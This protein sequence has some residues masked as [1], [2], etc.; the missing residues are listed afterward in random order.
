[1]AA[2]RIYTED[3][4]IAS[5]LIKRDGVIT[6]RYLYK[7]CYPLFKSIYDSYYT[8]CSCCKEFIDE[9]YLVV[10]SPSKNT[11]KCQLENYR[12]ESTLTSWLK[13]VCL[14]YCY[15]K[16][17]LKQRL[18][19]YEPL[20]YSTNKDNDDSASDRIDEIYGSVEIDFSELN[21]HDALEI[22]KQMP[23]KRYS[24][25]IELRYLEQKTNEE[26]A[27]ALGMTKENYYNKHKLAKEQYM[28]ILR[29]EVQHG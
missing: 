19:V 21:R 18:P 3:L 28:R 1:M 5:A 27:E 29:K 22:L 16:Y 9:V 11:G 26:T 25:L 7:Q 8:D 12:G 20:Q 17:E 10:L 23:N 14:F 2:L 4:Q 24:R 13:T 6:R 15:D